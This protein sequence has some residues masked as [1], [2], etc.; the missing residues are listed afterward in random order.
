M[1]K[2]KVNRVYMTTREVA[3]AVGVTIHT[4]RNWLKE[5]KIKGKKFGGRWLVDVETLEEVLGKKILGGE[6]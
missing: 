4:V 6:E 3:D 1:K 2:K 5:G